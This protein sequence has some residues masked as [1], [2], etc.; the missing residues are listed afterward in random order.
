MY[1]T[2]Q[3]SETLSNPQISDHPF[4]NCAAD[5]FCLQGHY[6]LLNVDYYSKFITVEN[7]RNP[8]S[9]SVIN[10]YKK[11]FSQS[12]IPKELTIVNS[13]KCSSHK[14]CSF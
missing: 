11:V 13:P 7:L 6:Y 12:C 10:K 8:Q 1:R 4:T 5:F 14:F 9:E 2:C 3:P